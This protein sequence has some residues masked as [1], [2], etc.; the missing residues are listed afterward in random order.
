MNLQF[1]FLLTFLAGAFTTWMFMTTSRRVNRERM[2]TIKKQIKS[3]GGDILSIDL[4][5]RKDCPISDEY[6]NPDLVYKFYKINYDVDHEVKKGWAVLDMKQN[7][8]G[9]SGA[10]DAHWTYRL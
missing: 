1:A 5:D 3:L 4:T 7:W 10:I 2:D 6:K 8:Y 9:P